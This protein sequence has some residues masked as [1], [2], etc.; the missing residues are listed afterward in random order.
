MPFPLRLFR[1]AAA[2]VNREGA[3][4]VVVVNT[5]DDRLVAFVLV[6][7]ANPAG[8]VDVLIE[9]SAVGDDDDGE[10][11]PKDEG[12]VLIEPL[13]EPVLVANDPDGVEIEAA[14]TSTALVLVIDLMLELVPV[15]DIR[16]AATV[17][18]A[19]TTT[20]VE[21]ADV[22]LWPEPETDRVDPGAIGAEAEAVG[23][24]PLPAVARAMLVTIGAHVLQA[25]TVTRVLALVEVVLPFV[26][27]Y[28]VTVCVAMIWLMIALG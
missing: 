11:A 7:L 6:I 25:C 16:P 13:G 5:E 1:R 9:S 10:A 2:P 23:A 15:P 19:V 18:V 3:A 28:A 24:T 4:S 17:P 26:S 22:P 8:I 12:I 21:T 14:V 27:K 20:I